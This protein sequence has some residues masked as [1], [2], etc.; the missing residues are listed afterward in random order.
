[1]GC[2]PANEVIK[3]ST[4]ARRGSGSADDDGVADAATA[5]CTNSP[6]SCSHLIFHEDNAKRPVRQAARKM[7]H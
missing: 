6:I 4:A 5:T 1:L 3:Q 7:S 2:N